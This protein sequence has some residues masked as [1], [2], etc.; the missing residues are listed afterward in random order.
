MNEFDSNMDALEEEIRKVVME[1]CQNSLANFK[2]EN[3]IPNLDHGEMKQHISSEDASGKD[4]PYT[5]QATVKTHYKKLNKFIRFIDYMII[6][7]KLGMVLES[8]SVL[9][10][11]IN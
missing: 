8:T 7:G 9:R 6:S 2:E 1:T 11:R 3:R 5:K 10:F 4:M